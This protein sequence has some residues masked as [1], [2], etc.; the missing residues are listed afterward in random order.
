MTNYV[1]IGDSSEGLFAKFPD[2]RNIQQPDL[3]SLARALV[4][5]G[6]KASEISH[7]WMAG[8]RMLT[9]GQQVALSSEMLG[10]ERNRRS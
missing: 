5:A 8:Y 4:F 7:D 6:V 2:G 1:N 3:R 10:I 9:A